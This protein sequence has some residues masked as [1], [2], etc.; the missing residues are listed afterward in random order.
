MASVS[1]WERNLKLMQEERRPE[2]LGAF[3]LQAC[4]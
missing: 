2:A 1:H 4:S 3:R